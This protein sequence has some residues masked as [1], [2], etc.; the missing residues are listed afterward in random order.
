MLISKSV[1]VTISVE[2]ITL[3]VYKVDVVKLLSDA[4]LTQY[5]IRKDGSLPQ[6]TISKLRNKELSLTLSTLDK[7]CTI[8]K[9]QPGD[10]IEWIDNEGQDV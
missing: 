6:S 8:L 5:R 10:L 9:C 2:V 4:G 1:C 7:V 3:I